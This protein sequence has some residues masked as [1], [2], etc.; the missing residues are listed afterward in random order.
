[1]YEVTG[2]YPLKDIPRNDLPLVVK[3]FSIAEDST[4]REM[5]QNGFYNLCEIHYLVRPFQFVV[6]N[7]FNKTSY[8][9]G[10]RYATADG[11]L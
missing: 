8:S 10:S 11:N 4:V 5:S 3:R 7:F 9:A 6:F 2:N 1:M